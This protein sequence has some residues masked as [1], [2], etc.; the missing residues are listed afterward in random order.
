[1][2]IPHK[3]IIHFCIVR[4]YKLFFPQVILSYLGLYA[5][6]VYRIAHKLFLPRMPMV[7]RIMD[8]F[9]EVRLTLQT[10]RGRL[11]Q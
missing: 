9:Q 11:A 2:S 8:Y 3:K 10:P 4:E 1:M 5:V 7:P 6:S